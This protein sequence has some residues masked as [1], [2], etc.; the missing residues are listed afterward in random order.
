[1]IARIFKRLA[2]FAVLAMGV[3]LTGCSNVDMTI[4]GEE[5]VP[6]A[7][8]D[9]GG[10]A[11]TDLVVATDANVIVSEG[12]TLNIVV[13][14][15]PDNALRFTL[16]EST[17]G[18]TSE[19][20]FSFTDGSPVVRITMPAPQSIVIAGSGAVQ[21]ATV[22][23]TPEIVIG[24]SGSVAIDSI[25]AE[26]LE[27]S[28]GGSGSIKGAGTA[29]RLEV[30]I[31][32]SGDVLLAG[33]KADRAEISIGGSGNVAFASDG[34]VEAN[35]AGAGDINVTG[36][37]KCTLNSFGSGNLNCTAANSEAQAEPAITEEN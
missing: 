29:Q 36:T 30:T 19:P 18:V 34:E 32:G 24:G 16:D 9:I 12:E 33:L 11:P 1:M 6:L 26:T 15:D 8:L 5:G 10:A 25:A 14:D 27:I 17:I 37:A 22:S 7:D 2:P 21:A 35:I 20:G 31:G 23:S 13:E 4:N 3:A 28:I